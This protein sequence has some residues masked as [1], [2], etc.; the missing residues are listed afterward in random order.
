MTNTNLFKCRSR[1]CSDNLIHNS[2]TQCSYFK[3]G[4]VTNG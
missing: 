2:D 1:I 3:S 4:C